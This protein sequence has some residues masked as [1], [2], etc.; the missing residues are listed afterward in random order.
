MFKATKMMSFEHAFK[1]IYIKEIIIKRDVV[2]KSHVGGTIN[3]KNI[4]NY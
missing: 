4:L 2:A 1:K 3:T